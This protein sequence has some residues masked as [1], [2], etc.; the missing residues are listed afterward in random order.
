MNELPRDGGQTIRNHE[1]RIDHLEK[2]RNT[3][4]TKDHNYVVDGLVYPRSHLP[5]VGVRVPP[6]QAKTLYSWE[7]YFLQAGTCPVELYLNDA[8]TAIPEGTDLGVELADGDYL[9]FYVDPSEDAEDLTILFAT[10]GSTT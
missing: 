2:R 8:G 7:V 4:G 1:D 5:R 3:A 6:G 10:Q 9:Y